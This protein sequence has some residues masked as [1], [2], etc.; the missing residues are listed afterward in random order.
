MN[1]NA[2]HEEVRAL[3]LDRQRVG[4][5]LMRYPRVSKHHADE[6]L[7]SLRTCSPIEISLLMSN[8]RLRPSLDAFMEEH[9]AHFRVTWGETAAFL[10]A[11]VG[12]LLILWLAWSAFA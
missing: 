4:E 7:G 8:K 5:L 1:Y 3:R 10:G 9:K 6:I 11:V 12:L 2:T